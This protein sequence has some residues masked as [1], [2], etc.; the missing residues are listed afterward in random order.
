MQY[1]Q[2][3]LPSLIGITLFFDEN[4]QSRT[5][6][7]TNTVCEKS[8]DHIGT[9]TTKKATNKRLG[10]PIP[11]SLQKYLSILHL[12][13][14]PIPRRIIVGD[15]V[16]QSVQLRKGLKQRREDEGRLRVLQ[17]DIQHAQRTNDK[18][19]LRNLFEKVTKIAYGEGVTPQMRE[20]FV[21]R[22][23]CTGWNQP[24]LDRIL[25][26]GKNR[27]IVE[28]GAGHGQ[29]ARAL[30]ELYENRNKQNPNKSYFDFVLTYDNMTSLPLSTQIYHQHTQA[31]H[32]YFFSKVKNY[33][34]DIRDV[35][36]QWTCRGRVLLMV[37]PP[38]GCMAL[39]C[40]KAYT[41]MGPE[42][43]TV[44]YVGEGRGGSTADKDFFDYMESGRWILLDILEVETQPGGK[45][46]EKLYI[47]QHHYDNN[48]A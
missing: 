5:V 32:D 34:G 20:D 43:D 19:K 11:S 36:R 21:V 44:V 10:A 4:S 37:F 31:A 27:G 39:D 16:F 6:S 35:L 47:F 45:G 22:Y 15:P 13:T 2:H 48:D 8:S 29:W 25:K 33:N 17:S 7:V 42:N 14:L 41:E 18:T 28:I 30:T 24:I 26:L 9:K 38:P 1:S 3:Y 12:S 23:G 40:V 46:F